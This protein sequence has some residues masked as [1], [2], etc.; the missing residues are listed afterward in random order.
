[1][2]Y[3]EFKLELPAVK[4]FKMK[5]IFLVHFTLLSWGLLH[6]WAPEVNRDDLRF[7]SR[8]AF[9]RISKYR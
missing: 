1:M 9:K 3:K 4:S 6:P 5:L 7:Q 2:G 8:G